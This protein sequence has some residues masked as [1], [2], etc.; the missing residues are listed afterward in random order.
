MTQIRICVI[1][2]QRDKHACMCDK[3]ACM[4]PVPHLTA[5]SQ[6]SSHL[7]WLSQAAT[8]ALHVSF[9]LDPEGYDKAKVPLLPVTVLMRVEVGG[10]VVSRPRKRYCM[11]CML[12]GLHV[13]HDGG[14]GGWRV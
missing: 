10:T 7:L 3:H 2:R 6:G 9:G 14:R 8:I 13:M 11:A 5:S 12:P 4:C 1:S